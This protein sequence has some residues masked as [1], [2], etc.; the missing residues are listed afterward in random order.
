MLS[1]RPFLIL[2]AV[3][4]ACEVPPAPAVAP[5]LKTT[6]RLT[7]PSPAKIRERLGLVSTDVPVSCA[8]ATG[9]DFM[10]AASVSGV[11]SERAQV[12][13]RILVDTS[14]SSGSPH[15]YLITDEHL[16]EPSDEVDL[17]LKS[18][19]LKSSLRLGVILTT[20]EDYLDKREFVVLL[21]PFGTNGLELLWSGEGDRLQ[22]SMD[23]CTLWRTAEFREGDD[24]TVKLVSR[25]TA[26]YAAQDLDP[27]LA[28]SI[29][30]EC[31]AKPER[32]VKLVGCRSQ[33]A[34][35]QPRVAAEVLRRGFELGRVE[36][37]A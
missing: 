2:L 32:A 23:S 16:Y 27:E 6:A 36:L 10:L 3:V 1:P 37:Q 12:R 35:T 18:D 5:V 13:L 25:T 11:D 14:R 29:R 26:D 24:R 4:P 9:G 19:K 34:V 15:D 28:R 8:V 17:L 22:R 20:G 7:C 31:I 21:R 30:T 33:I